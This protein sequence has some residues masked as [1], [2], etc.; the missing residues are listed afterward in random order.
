M[1]GLCCPMRS[2]IRALARGNARIVLDDCL[3]AHLS[4]C[5]ECQS[6]LAALDGADDS[7][8]SSVQQLLDPS[9]IRSIPILQEAVARLIPVQL[10][11]QAAT[12]PDPQSAPSIGGSL[13]EFRIIRELPGGGM[14]RIYEAIQQSLGRRVALK[15]IRGDRL[16]PQKRERF[17]RE[18]AVLAALH[19]THIVPIH[20][21]G[22]VG[23]LQYFA[24]P[25]IEGVTL[26]QIIGTVRRQQSVSPN[27][28]TPTL[29]KLAH[30]LDSTL[31]V[32]DDAL[33]TD[34][35]PEN[36]VAPPSPDKF[37]LSPEYFRS[38]A[39]VMLDVADACH[40]VHKLQILHRDL[41]PSNLMVDT[42]GA[43]WIIDFGLAYFLNDGERSSERG[44]GA[45]SANNIPE[46]IRR[47]LTQ[48]EGSRPGTPPY[49]SP[50]QWKTQGMDVRTDVWGLGV[51]LYEMLTLRPAFF[52]S[53]REIELK[54]QNNDPPP[55]R[56]LVK[57]VPID[58]VAICSKALKKEPSARYQT[59]QDFAADLR[60]WL[61]HE[62]VT[63]QRTRLPRR[64]WLWVRRNRGWAAAMVAFL[65]ACAGV[66]T[67]EIRSERNRAAFA[68]R[69]NL[70]QKMQNLRLLPHQATEGANWLDDGRVLVSEAARIRK[71][72]VLR[73]QAAAFLA[74]ANASL[75]K[76]MRGF[77]ASS[78]AFDSE[79]R[80]LLIGGSD[81]DEAKIWDSVTDESQK[82][83]L[84]GGGP[85][86][87]RPDGAAWQL[88][89][90]EQFTA[91][92]QLAASKKDRF[93]L[94]LWDITKHRLVRE[95]KL[96]EQSLG[97]STVDLSISNMTLTRDGKFAAAAATHDGGTNLLV[98]WDT[99]DGNVVRQIQHGGQVS[100]IAVSDDGA[101]LAAGDAQGQITICPLPGGDPFSLRST[102][103]VR[104]NCLSFGANA[105]WRVKNDV[106]EK[107]LLAS[108][109]HGGGVTLWDLGRRAPSAYCRGSY[110][111]I[112]ALA[113]SPDGVTL[114]STGRNDTRLWEIATGRQLLVLHYSDSMT[115]IAF[116]RDA[117]KMAVS[118]AA[119]YVSTDPLYP[120]FMVWDL[121]YHR[122]IQ[123]LRGLES[124]IA[125]S[126]VCFSR[127]GSR[128]A[129]LSLG[130]QAAIWDLPS[131]YL[132]CRFDVTPGFTADNA[133]LAFSPDGRKFAVS[134]GSEARLWDLDAPKE[135][136]WKLPEGLLD[137]LVFDETGTR[138]FLFRMET[139]DWIHPPDSRSDVGDYPRVCRMRDLLASP[140]RDL[141]RP[142]K[143]NPSW[144]TGFFNRRVVVVQASSDGR[145]L[146]VTGDRGPRADNKERLVKV[147][148]TPTGKEVFSR[149]GQGARLDAAGRLMLFAPEN[150]PPGTLYSLIEIPS[151]KW[152]TF[153]DPPASAL[154]PGARVSAVQ[155]ASRFGFAFHRVGDPTPLATLGIDVLS[156]EG[157]ATFSGDGTRLAWGNQDGTVTVC[158]LPDVQKRLTAIGFG[159]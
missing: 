115:G 145:Y 66:A 47:H 62:P 156:A 85:V 104:V 5:L 142:G 159:W 75:A 89:A 93:P 141:R 138:L 65:L 51:T 86:I 67:A 105:A 132:R 64:V 120:G 157:T 52:G 127:D 4:I 111:D 100:A 144:E 36:K 139:S 119:D 15:T 129:A 150:A 34:R 41:K 76:V 56:E 147:F 13:G 82:S 158:Y 26:Q 136:V 81:N 94:R 9:A 152:V 14:G 48:E 133:G 28:R 117:K 118:V 59:A 112:Y 7:F 16:S 50:E 27:A 108:G 25:Y 146:M 123:A 88:T 79:A 140:E 155:T 102:K 12:E 38:V 29:A 74:G 3:A 106:P 92:K 60:R 153:V 148:E 6:E 31:L 121:E 22:Q 54:V 1:S 151:S 143:N 72:D 95:L 84:A 8:L 63:A 130:W 46:H 71:D 42:A 55:P 19:Q 107:W 33:S 125:H 58:L 30:R 99:S 32:G 87:F 78:V 20:T 96:P 2:Q 149:P 45:R 137:T 109:D 43:C 23:D 97:R 135:T 114:A 126:K 101:Y 57:G 113:F 124:Q 68:E 134:V 10:D 122:G 11:L 49:M 91:T 21:A 18:Q 35:T 131:G 44:E 53:T 103:R 37:R 98:V 40:H 17:L 154:G 83:G 61:N 77:R 39:T 80:R 70:I 24:M 73:D 90:T 128:I 116:S 69:E 110:Y